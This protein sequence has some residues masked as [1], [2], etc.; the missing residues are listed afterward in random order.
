[1]K[2]TKFYL[3]FYQVY[4]HLK[5]LFSIYLYNEVKF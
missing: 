3:M 4:E 1:M 2:R 5:K